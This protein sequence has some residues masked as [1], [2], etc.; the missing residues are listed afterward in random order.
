MC[1]RKYTNVHYSS[2]ANT[3]IWTVVSVKNIQLHFHIAAV[4][5]EATEAFNRRR[6]DSVLRIPESRDRLRNLSA[7]QIKGSSWFHGHLHAFTSNKFTK[8]LNSGVALIVW[9]SALL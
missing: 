1:L 4:K 5:R 3:R 7:T 8:S 2:A 9:Q 6:V